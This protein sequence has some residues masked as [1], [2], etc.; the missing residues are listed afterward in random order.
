[1]STQR[2]NLDRVIELGAGERNLKLADGADRDGPV[3]FQ[4]ASSRAA[5]Q[6]AHAE[7]ARQCAYFV[8]HYRF[9]L[10]GHQFLSLTTPA[11]DRGQPELVHNGAVLHNRPACY[12]RYFRADDDVVDHR[13]ER[14][15]LTYLMWLSI[16]YQHLA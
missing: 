3:G 12:N 14:C 9:R 2:T 8:G 1:M 13:L 4:Q 16:H 5:V 11:S 10:G 15:Y 6:D 7:L